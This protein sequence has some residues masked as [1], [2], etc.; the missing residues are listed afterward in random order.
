MARQSS[1]RRLNIWANGLR[2]GQWQLP[3]NGNDTLTYDPHWIASP[4][5]RPLSLSMPFTLDNAPLRG[6]MVRNYFDNLLPDSDAIR[7][8][9]QKRFHTLSTT[10]FDLLAEIGRDCVGAVQLLPE[11]Q[12]PENVQTIEAEILDDAQIANLLRLTAAMPTAIGQHDDS[13]EDFRISIAG[14]QEKTALLRHQGQWCRPLG[15]TPTTHIFKLPLGL[16]GN[17]Q[18]D[19][20]TS[21]ENEWLCANILRRFGLPV[22]GCDIAHFE[23]QKVLIVE[24]FDRHM[25]GQ[26]YWLRMPQEDFCQAT[27]TPADAKY[28]S[29]GGPG[30]I[31]IARLLQQSETS[32]HDLRVLLTAQL[33][34][35]LMAATD[36]H[37]KNFSIFLLPGARYRLTPLYDV[38]SAWPVTGKGPNKLDANRLRLAMAVKGKN[39]HYRLRDI[40]RRHFNHTAA[41]CGWGPNMEDVITAVLDQLPGI[42]DTAA[43]D[44]PAEFP[45]DVFTAIRDG[46]EQ[47]A[48]RL[49]RM[50]S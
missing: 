42:L 25:S 32:K 44:L 5:G 30:I 38:L 3:T 43:N 40:Q 35:W 29:D 37:A 41:L 16:V 8:R 47:A 34:F 49:A 4:Q 15:A 17:R 19:M 27:G 12:T 7:R 21:V 18:A 22:A 2:V 20:R 14:A 36:G 24:R 33:L 28:E 46:M 39:T 10:A 31:Q 6:A 11:G 50:P 9:I 13:D 45:E 48:E 26:G 23:D 1:T